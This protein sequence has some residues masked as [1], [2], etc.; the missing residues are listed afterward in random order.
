MRLKSLK[1]LVNGRCSQDALRD[2][3]L[4]RRDAPALDPRAVTVDG[5][6]L[7]GS[8]AYV[9][10]NRNPV[11]CRDT[12]SQASLLLGFEPVVRLQTSRYCVREAGLLI[13]SY[14]LGIFGNLP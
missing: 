10:S 14:P 1:L 7:R 6:S 8:I 11:R 13:T 3:W 5:V 12:L 4:R 9:E 2:G